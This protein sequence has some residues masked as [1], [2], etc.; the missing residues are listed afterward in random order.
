M[1]DL[2]LSRRRRRRRLVLASAVVG[3]IVLGVVAF[4]VLRGRTGD[5]HKG[6]KVE[7]QAPPPPK[8]TETTIDW[9]NYHRDLAHTGYLPSRLSPPYRR[10]WLFSGKVLMEFPPIVSG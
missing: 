7:F 6:N 9:P 8:P 1:R 4:L 10:L 3:V 2:F 5:V